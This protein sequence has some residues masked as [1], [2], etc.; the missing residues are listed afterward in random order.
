MRGGSEAPTLASQ[1]ELFGRAAGRDGTALY[2]RLS[3]SIAR[4]PA[5]LELVERAPLAQRRPNLLFAAV[6]Y[7]LLGT[8]D[9]PLAAYYPTVSDWLGIPHD[10]PTDG[11]PFVEFAGCCRRRRG[12]LED[13]LATRATQTNEVGRSA[14]LLPAFATVAARH[15]R[16][17]AVV[18][19]GASAGLNLLFDRY[20]YTY[21][22]PDHTTIRAGDRDSTV[23]IESALRHGVL[24]ALDLPPVAWRAG[25]DAR[26]VDPT[27]PDRALWLLSCQWPHHLERFRQLRRALDLAR[28]TPRRVE[29]MAGDMVSDLAATVA[30]APGDAHLCITHTWAA[31]YLSPER[32]VDL[33]VAVRS[34][35]RDRPVSWIFAELPYEVPGL[36]VPEPAG[37]AVRGAT[38]LAL[39][40]L[41]DGREEA[42]RLAD[43]HHHGRWIHWWGATG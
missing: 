2:E 38:A 31:A 24:P 39:I 29:V 23:V 14:L 16:P 20:A 3:S 19:L 5:L 35:A 22:S 37:D 40:D 6:H 1:F 32:Q 27:D 9:D 8:A 11:D 10:A 21:R 25:L 13:L 26:P 4:D 43:V 18:D 42:R 30:G 17:L 28:A 12:Q 41:S 33:S 36:P 7:L 34:V 15:G